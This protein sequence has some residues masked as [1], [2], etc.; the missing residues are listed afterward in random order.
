MPLADADVQPQLLTLA[1][2]FITHDQWLTTHVHPE[3]K[4]KEVKLWILSKCLGVALDSTLHPWVSRTTRRTGSTA[5]SHTPSSGTPSGQQHYRPA[6]PITFAPEPRR[7]PISPILFAKGANKG[8]KGKEKATTSD[9]GHEIGAGKAASAEGTP[10]LSSPVDGYEEDDEWDTA[11][12]GG[13]SFDESELFRDSPPPP[14][15]APALPPPPSAPMPALPPALNIG[16]WAKYNT[17]STAYTLLRFSTGQILEDDMSLEM[18]DLAPY[19]LLELHAHADVCIMPSTRLLSSSMSTNNHNN[20]HKSS[21]ASQ[22][23]G[24][25]SEHGHHRSTSIYSLSSS[26]PPPAGH[27]QH[28]HP[29]RPT[30]IRLPPLNRTL[31]EKYVQPYWEGPVRALRVVWRQPALD[32]PLS[33]FANGYGYGYGGVGNAFVDP[34]AMALGI[35][36]PPAF[37]SQQ[38][39]GRETRQGGSGSGSG[40]GHGQGQGG[41]GGFVVGPGGM[42]GA[43]A[44]DRDDPNPTHILPLSSLTAIRGADY[45]AKS[46]H[47][48]QTPTTDPHSPSFPPPQH[49]Q[50]HHSSH[51]YPYPPSLAPSSKSRNKGKRK[52]KDKENDKEKEKH[53]RYS[54]SGSTFP[55]GGPSS[56]YASGSDTDSDLHRHQHHDPHPGGGGRVGGAKMIGD[57]AIDDLRIV[58]VKFR[59]ADRLK[60]VLVSK[61]DGVATYRYVSGSEERKEKERAREGEGE[62]GSR[63]GVTTVISAGDGKGKEKKKDKKGKEKEKEKERKRKEKDGKAKGRAKVVLPWE[64]DDKDKEKEKEKRDWISAFSVKKDKDKDKH[65]ERKARTKDKERGG[66]VL[67]G[68]G[69]GLGL[70]LGLAVGVQDAKERFMLERAREKQLERGREERERERERAALSEADAEASITF[71]RR[72]GEGMTS[73]DSEE[74]PVAVRTLEEGQSEVW[75]GPIPEEV[76]EAEAEEG[77]KVEDADKD[78]DKAEEVEELKDAPSDADDPDADADA[79]ADADGEG[80]GEPDADTDTDSDSPTSH[81]HHTARPSISSHA[82]PHAELTGVVVASDDEA[83]AES[84]AW[85]SPVFAH[86]DDSPDGGLSDGDWSEVGVGMGKAADAYRYGYRY[87]YR[88][89]SAEAARWGVGTTE[90]TTEP[91][92]EQE[93]VHEEEDRVEKEKANLERRK[94]KERARKLEEEKEKEKA[95]W[96]VLDMGNDPA[97]S[98]FLR[99][100]HRHLSPP[101]SSSFV[102]QAPNFTSATATSTPTPTPTPT[103][104]PSPVSPRPSGSSVPPFQWAGFSAHDKDDE[105]GHATTHTSHDV[106]PPSPVSTSSHSDRFHY[107]HPHHPPALA[108]LSRP[109]VTGPKTLGVLPYPEWRMEV[110]QRAQRAGMGDIGRAMKWVLWQCNTQLEL[111]LQE[112]LNRDA[113]D[114]KTSAEIRRKRRETMSLKHRRRSTT[115]HASTITRGSRGKTQAA[116]GALPEPEQSSSSVT[117][118][119]SDFSEDTGKMIGMSDSEEGSEAEWQGWMADLHRQHQA[120]AQKKREEEA[121]KRRAALAQAMK[122]SDEELFAPPKNVEED[123]R[124]IRELRMRYEPSAVVTTMHAAAPTSQST[125]SATL[126]SASSSESLSRR[127]RAMS[128]SPVDRSSSPAGTSSHSHHGHN[129][130]QSTSPLSNQVFRKP[131]LPAGSGLSHSTSMYATGLRSDSGTA[132]QNMRRPSMPIITADQTYSLLQGSVI[133]PHA[134]ILRSPTASNFSFPAPQRPPTSPSP[135]FSPDWSFEKEKP[136]ASSSSRTNASHSSMPRRAS[137]AGLVSMGGVGG[138]LGRSSS[139]IARPGLLKKD[140]T[141]EAE[142][143]KE[144]EK[145]VKEKEDKAKEKEKKAKEKERANDLEKES[146][147]ARKLQRPKLSLATSSTHTLVTQPATSQV[148]SPT[149]AEMG[150]SIMRRVKSGSSLNAAV[151]LEEGRPTSPTEEGSAAPQASKKKRTVLVNRIVR[152]LDSAM[153]FV[154]GK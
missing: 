50:H 154:D 113:D 2:R 105:A 152:G 90:G 3:W 28:P 151:V 11:E 4:V 98:S 67:G 99:V 103:P 85:S 76:A 24:T 95:E 117:V 80:E 130:S 49:H 129:Y 27:H 142:R 53:S 59:S 140:A 40:S 145:R 55:S 126:Y 63:M 61:V 57:E 83:A 15:P 26:P 77:G 111:D 112:V 58:C 12:D 81:A 91:W 108:E 68:M 135:I 146:K 23:L 18:Y 22:P 38:H 123:R 7:R 25:V 115:S 82:H 147:E 13:S 97:F 120:E 133:S 6:S 122:G 71:A 29:A 96:I 109:A 104:F 78:R 16:K 9:A 65:R 46:T 66:M 54:I 8:R 69:M 34:R 36:H 106:E 42:G 30:R 148:K 138:S 72:S 17:A 60:K 134:S 79:D 39:R 20:N 47:L 153:D 74:E 43:G 51:L 56:S 64:R 149:A 75:G 150:R 48:S 139:V 88:Y 132:D 102:T 107:A 141:K 136:L 19:E 44:G 119:D 37:G 93:S 70:G 45:L 52:D 89:E 116:L 101:M 1:C 125:P 41:A 100:L 143:L 131:P 62:G 127:H 5:H 124:Q 21:A 114:E 14:L 86:T 31:L 128:F 118:Y 137:S 84:E 73:S 94:E 32:V 144:K 92:P 121:E 10:T 35:G 110:A 33:N 87:G